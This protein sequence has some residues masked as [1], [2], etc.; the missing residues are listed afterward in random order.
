MFFLILTYS[1]EFDNCVTKNVIMDDVLMDLM[2]TAAMNEGNLPKPLDGYRVIKH[3][4][5]VLKRMA[6]TSSVLLQEDACRLSNAI[7][8]CATADGD[9]C[10]A[11]TL[12]GMNDPSDGTT[13]I[14]GSDG[15]SMHVVDD[16]GIEK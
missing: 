11:E 10:Y 2:I 16:C 15:Q 3:F 9:E 7:M 14:T 8:S 12:K 1:L 5:H 4:C 6:S 13:I